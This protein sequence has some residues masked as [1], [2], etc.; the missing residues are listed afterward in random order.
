[1][2][3]AT[4][5]AL[6]DDLDRTRYRGQL[7]FHNYNEPLADPHLLP[8]LEQAR[9]ALPKAY[10]MIFT[11]G[12]LLDAALL[13]RLV[14]AQVD[15]VRVTLYPSEA[16]KDVEPKLAAVDRRLKRLGLDDPGEALDL[17][18]WVLREVQVQGLKLIVRAPRVAFFGTRGGAVKNLTVGWTGERYWPCHQPTASA[19]IDFHGNLK[20]C[21]H[22][23]D[24]KDKANA[25]AIVGNV[26]QT[27]FSALWT[28]E[29]MNRIRAQ[30]KKADFTG[31]PVCA[32]CD[33]V[34]LP[35][36]LNARERKRWP[37]EILELVG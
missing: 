5:R 32:G 31:L 12:D 24:A 18:R 3:D 4:W 20:I 14:D 34:W 29:R 6:L 9:A 37:Q 25:S 35:P 23:Y 21:C 33:N 13:Q 8:R 26:G 2:T 22:I 19:A 17:P 36:K 7:A 10:L 28:S 15:E 16:L 27:P 30:L 1:M 11:N